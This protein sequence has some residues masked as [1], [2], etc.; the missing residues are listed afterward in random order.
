MGQLTNDPE[1]QGYSYRSHTSVISNSNNGQSDDKVSRKLASVE[2]V[3]VSILGPVPGRHPSWI[4]ALPMPTFA[5]A[6]IQRVICTAIPRSIVKK[7]ET[8]GS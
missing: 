6:T 1:S 7:G 3:G 5:Y 4:M 8:R 2:P